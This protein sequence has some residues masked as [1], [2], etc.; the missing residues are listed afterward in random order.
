LAGRS[1]RGLRCGSPAGSGAQLAASGCDVGRRPAR[2]SAGSDLSGW[3]HGSSSHSDDDDSDDD[4]ADGESDDA[5]RDE[6]TRDVE[7]AG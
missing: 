4:D 5:D 1:V 3:L 6:G 7:I 2:G